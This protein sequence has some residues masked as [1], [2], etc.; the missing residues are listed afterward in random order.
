MIFKDNVFKSIGEA[1]QISDS[2][3][4]DGDA[5]GKQDSDSEGGSDDSM[6]EGGNPDQAHLQQHAELSPDVIQTCIACGIMSDKA[7]PYVLHH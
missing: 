6:L 5:G 4:S 1:M 2:D 7:P 3:N